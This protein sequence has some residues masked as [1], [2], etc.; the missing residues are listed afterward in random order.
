VYL[1]KDFLLKKATQKLFYQKE[2]LYGIVFCP[3]P[4]TAAQTP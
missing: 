3:Q 4:E 2:N 1:R